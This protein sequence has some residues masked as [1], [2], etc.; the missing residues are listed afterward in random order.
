MDARSCRSSIAVSG[1]SP[2][3]AVISLAGMPDHDVTGEGAGER[4]PAVARPG[5]EA[6]T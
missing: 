4:G 1:T 3:A 2:P 6:E 5:I